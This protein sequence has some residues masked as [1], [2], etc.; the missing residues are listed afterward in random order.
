MRHACSPAG[1]L[2]GAAHQRILPT[3]ELSS[4][5]AYLYQ[6]MSC[7]AQLIRASVPRVSCR[8]YMSYACLPTGELPGAAHPRMFAP[9]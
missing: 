3:S 2:S 1:E 5:S 4:S 6:Q 7:Q 8:S 9:R